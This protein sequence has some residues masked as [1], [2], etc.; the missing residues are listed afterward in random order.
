VTTVSVDIAAV[1]E[2]GARLRVVGGKTMGMVSA[3]PRP[4][5]SAAAAGGHAGV[6]TAIGE[7]FD[8]WFGPSG[9][10]ARGGETVERL[11]LVLGDAAASYWGLDT[12]LADLPVA[13]GGGGR[14]LPA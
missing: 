2:A 13:A 12:A 3:T 11:G 14:T 10:L 8:T 9:S 5:V 6:A 4:A 1:L 7:V